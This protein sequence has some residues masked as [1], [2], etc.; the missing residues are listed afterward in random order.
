VG[1]TLTPH[2]LVGLDFA[3]LTSAGWIGG[4]ARI[5]NCDLMFTW[6]PVGH[7]FFLRGGGGLSYFSA[8]ESVFNTSQSGV[9]L[10]AGGGYAFWL[11][12]QFNLTVNLDGSVQNYQASGI[13]I[14]QSR[15]A[16]VWLGA[17]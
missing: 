1:V 7:G 11:G 5:T 2:L 4:S 15:Y 14:T 12:R 13:G 8:S 17:G 10:S 16:V 3:R 6:F 9:N